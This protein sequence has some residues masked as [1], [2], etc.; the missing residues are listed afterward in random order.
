MGRLSKARI[1]R[2]RNLRREGYLQ[3]E[4]AK[5]A[6][7]NIKTVR[8]YAPLPKSTKLRGKTAQDAMRAPLSVDL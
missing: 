1:D 2:I 3:K 5:M 7:V 4:V 8:T 6:N